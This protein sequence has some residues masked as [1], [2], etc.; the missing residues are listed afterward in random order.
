[1]AYAQVV[2]MTAPLQIKDIR[3]DGY[4]Q[5]IVLRS[6]RSSASETLP[7]V[8]YFHGGGFVG[9]GLADTTALAS[10]LAKKVPAW[11]I[12]VGYSLAPEFPFP[13][14]A[15]DAYLALQWVVGAAPT[16]QADG[17]RV[18]AVG[19]DAGG[20]I[21]AALGAV[22]RDRAGVQVTVQVL[23]APMLDPSMS[24]LLH[25]AFADACK[26]GP[27]DCS[28]AYRAYLPLVAQRMH[29]YAAPLESKR[30]R[31]LPPTLIATAERDIARADGEVF[32]RELISSGVP[33]EITRYG[34]ATHD[35]LVSHESALADTVAF[36]RR[37]L[38]AG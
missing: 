37:R 30:L 15:E 21:A 12:A 1:M 27:E 11:V 20:N 3:I 32:A 34:G 31:N 14:A 6:F 29:P 33:V 4:A 19:H 35:G 5:P 25:P 9:G 23:L 10:V 8:L 22:A 16:H 28:R 24:R 7:V 2:E 36:L 13:S 17:S 18:A 26:P 38:A